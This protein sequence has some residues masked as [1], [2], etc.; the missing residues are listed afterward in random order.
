MIFNYSNRERLNFVSH[1]KLT[2][3]GYLEHYSIQYVFDLKKN[4]GE[5]FA[6]LCL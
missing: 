5:Y 2:H 3:L 1:F 6:I 4:S